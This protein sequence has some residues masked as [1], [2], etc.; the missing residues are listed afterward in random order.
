MP[1]I[2]MYVILAILWPYML[3][4]LF[5]WTFDPVQWGWYTRLALALVYGFFAWQVL[6]ALNAM[7]RRYY[8]T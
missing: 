5:E 1:F 3:A 7:K 4:S 6:T 2:I 8:G